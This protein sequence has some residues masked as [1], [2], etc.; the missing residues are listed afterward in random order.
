MDNDPSVPATEQLD[1]DECWHMLRSSSLGR[2]A[3]WHD[4]HPEI[5]PINYIVD[6]GTLVVRTGTGTKLAAAAGNSEVAFEVDGRNQTAGEAWSVV[7]KA[8]MQQIGVSTEFHQEVVRWLFP[9]ES[10]AKDHFLRILPY[11]I[12]GRRFMLTPPLTWWLHPHPKG[13]GG[14]R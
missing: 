12:T 6:R 1:T 8:T 10:G 14:N 11:E 5:F 13:A 3:V 4:N 2:L 9:W 7:V